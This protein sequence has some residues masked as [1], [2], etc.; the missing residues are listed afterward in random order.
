M[1]G[2]SLRNGPRCSPYSGSSS[3]RQSFSRSPPGVSGHCVRGWSGEPCPCAVEHVQDLEA[4][5]LRVP[6]QLAGEQDTP[7]DL[8]PGL[9][10]H[11][12]PGFVLEDDPRAQELGRPLTRDHCSVRHL[13]TARSS[14]STALCA[15]TCGDQPSRCSRYDTPRGV[16]R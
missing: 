12:L 13:A 11:F 7:A 8:V 3:D 5:A 9:V 4:G 14:R 6:L 2:G 15:G 10:L 16:Y 1:S